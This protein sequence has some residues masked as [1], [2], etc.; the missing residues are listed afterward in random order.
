MYEFYIE[1]KKRIRTVYE[2]F[3][4]LQKVTKPSKKGK[5]LIICMDKFLNCHLSSPAIGKKYQ[6]VVTLL[7][8]LQ[9][10][11]KEQV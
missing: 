5:Q 8:E 11:A 2:S 4:K 3:I 6:D 9:N 7:E 10:E 1:A